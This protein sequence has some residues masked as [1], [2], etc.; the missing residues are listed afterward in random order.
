[1]AQIE[2]MSHQLDSAKPV[3]KTN[4]AECLHELANRTGRR[5]IILLF[6]DFLN[7]ITPLE[8]AL[9][10]LRYRNHEVVLFHVLHHDELAF[11]LDGMV[12]FV[13][14]ETVGDILTN[15]ADLRQHYL[16]ALKEYRD[17]LEQMAARNRVEYVLVDTSQGLGSVLSDYL[18]RR[19]LLNRGR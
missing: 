5:E 15:P 17:E 13:G 10:Q 12:R 11:E 8:S 7:P 2:R 6:S 18:H 16:A 9:Q 19:S 3:R 14:L 1:M 4:L